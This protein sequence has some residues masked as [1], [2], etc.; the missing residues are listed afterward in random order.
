MS[1]LRAA[2]THNPT[3]AFLVYAH[4]NDRSQ[5]N[6]SQEVA[7]N[8]IDWL[9]HVGCNLRSDRR[10][11]GL[12]KGWY[13]RNPVDNGPVHDIL[14]SQMCLLPS[15]LYEHSVEKVVLFGSEL[16]GE[17]IKTPFYQS[18]QTKLRNVFKTTDQQDIQKIKDSLRQV[19]EEN[20][21][22]QDFH[23]VLTEIALLQIFR[24]PKGQSLGPTSIIPVVL[25]G[26]YNVVFPPAMFPLTT[27]RITL[28]T[29]DK[30]DQH[31]CFF[32][33]LSRLFEQEEPLLKAVEYTYKECIEHPPQDS[34]TVF[35]THVLEMF[36]RAYLNSR[37]DDFRSLSFANFLQQHQK[38]IEALQD[39]H[40][41]S[42]PE[43]YLQER[44]LS[45]L[46]R[47]CHQA[48]LPAGIAYSEQKDQ[49]PKR[50]D[51]TCLWALE[52]TTYTHWR[53]T[54]D[55]KLL[56]ISAG[57]G[58]GK[59]VLCRAILEEDLPKYVPEALVIYFFFKSTTHDQRSVHACLRALLHQLISQNGSLVQHALPMFQHWGKNFAHASFRE[60]WAIFMAMVED[61]GAGNIICLLD[62]L[63]E[64]DKVERPKLISSIQRFCS[65][66]QQS[67]SHNLRFLVTSRPYLDL[68]AAFE[69]ITDHSAGIKLDGALESD[70]IKREID[71][72]IE[73]Q[74]NKLAREIRFP[75]EVRDYLQ[76]TLLTTENRTYLWLRLV[77]DLLPK[78]WPMTVKQMRKIIHE[79]PR[80][81]NEAY[82]SLL[83]QCDDSQYAR[84]VLK[85]VLAA[86]RPLTVD[87][88]DVALNL[89][90]DTKE[91][92]DL[93][94]EGSSNLQRTLPGRCGLMISIID[95]KVYFIHQ[96]VREF[97]LQKE[98]QPFDQHKTSIRNDEMNQEWIWRES[99]SVEEA[100]QFMARLCMQLLLFSRFNS[101]FDI[102]I[103]LLDRHMRKSAEARI[104]SRFAFHSYAYLNWADHYKDGKIVL[105]IGRSL[106]Q[107][108]SM[109]GTGRG[110]LRNSIHMAAAEGYWQIFDHLLEGV[111]DINED[112]G[113][114]WGTVL[115][116]AAWGGDL[117]MV[118]S[119]VARGA[120]VNAQAG[121]VGN[122]LM[123]ATFGGHLD[124][125]RFLLDTGAEV[126][127]QNGRHRNA[128][129]EARDRHHF[130][131]EKLLL[132][133]GAKLP[134]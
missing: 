24:F 76:N 82:E 70:N 110:F 127:A 52:H 84:D 123:A 49:N 31:R 44:D 45:N 74:V 50:V 85:I 118:R 41:R 103:G 96:T 19:V 100:H 10:P 42:L 113:G 4:K 94:L 46:K 14:E 111:A 16:L 93:D 20:L 129:Q 66:D 125:V 15:P 30:C 120:N 91:Y 83:S 114:L 88:I 71:L 7:T 105:D 29:L 23:H 26:K 28:Q 73:N 133:R 1:T 17:Y 78:R 63:D 58:C 68:K 75:V 97:L 56:W 54:N 25:N 27:A 39:L 80:G 55:K 62:A 48:L 21:N 81:I 36:Y 43:N 51:N 22:D 64:C 13:F 126:N 99:F 86:Y 33:V 9:N 69:D 101:K 95:S 102:S 108:N 12:D 72:V 6:A 67:R 61:P 5:K 107:A 60:L 35:E 130:E 53:D 79:L 122:A 40:G 112:I 77:L 38:I 57:A 89:S 132:A 115:A 3:S 124:V 131:V 32:R 90:K 8:Y 47:Q 65:A 98:V 59:S 34:G 92:S 106:V 134:P 116:A 37:G 109:F 128:L 119:L 117:N 18:Y 2:L 121:N 87:E 104:K 11:L